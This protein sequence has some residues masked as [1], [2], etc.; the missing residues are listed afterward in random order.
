MSLITIAELLREVNWASRYDSVRRPVEKITYD[1]NICDV[2]QS[3]RSCTEKGYFTFCYE[4]YKEDF[5]ACKNIRINSQNSS[6][7]YTVS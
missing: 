7:V 3:F 4:I 1:N 2:K 5:Y 6:M